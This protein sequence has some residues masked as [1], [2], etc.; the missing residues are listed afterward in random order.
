M[1]Q[2][3]LEPPY[4]GGLAILIDPAL[5]GGKGRGIFVAPAHQITDA[6]VVTMVAEG[7]GV[8]TITI[9]ESTAM[10]LGLHPQGNPTAADEPYFVNSVEAVACTETGISARERAITLRAIG[11]P[12]VVRA[13]LASPGHIMVQVARN[14]LRNGAT[15]PE[16]ANALLSALGLTRFAAWTDI[17]DRA[18]EVGDADHCRALGQRLGLACYDA[19]AARQFARE[20]LPAWDAVVR[21]SEAHFSAT[22]SPQ[23]GH[24]SN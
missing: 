11:S 1:S 14:V 9:N 22:E 17:L 16:T 15:L 8:C 21:F 12:D 2:S 13:D 24:S 18:G 7:M 5:M 3:N 4:T 10:R 23:N 6:D 19:Q 20:K